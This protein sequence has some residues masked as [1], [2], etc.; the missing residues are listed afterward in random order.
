MENPAEAGGFESLD[1]LRPTLEPLLAEQVA[2]RFLAWTVAN[3]RALGADEPKTR[4]EF[5]GSLY[6]Q[7]TFKYHAWSF[8]ELRDKLAPVRSDPD[9]AAV[10][11]RTGC[12]P[13]LDA[14][15]SAS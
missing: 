15:L 10:L 3:A 6:E 1:S 7:N 12:A 5:D 11:D 14:E 4:L 8:G 13:Y 9:L 2:G